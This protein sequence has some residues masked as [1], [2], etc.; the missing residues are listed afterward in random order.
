MASFIWTLVWWASGTPWLTTPVK[1][2][3]VLWN[4]SAWFV[5][6]VACAIFDVVIDRPALGIR[7]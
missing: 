6:L 2:D 4:W 5:A 1:A 7:L 3:Q